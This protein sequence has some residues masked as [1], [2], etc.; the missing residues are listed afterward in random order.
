MSKKV[1][2]RRLPTGV[3][4]LDNLLGGGLPEFSFNLIAGMPGSGKT[5]LAH[6]I[7]FS[8]AN[9]DNRVLF[10]TVLGEPALKMLRYQQQFS[11][12]DI[13][14]INDSIRFVNLSTDLMGGNFDRVLSRISEEVKN[15]TPGLVFVDS[16]RSV[17][18]STKN[19]DTGMSDLQR[20]VQQLGM[21]MT[22]WQTTSFLL[23]EYLAPEAESSPIFTVADGI[24]WLSQNMHH[25]SMVR[26]M[27]VVKMRGQAQAA[28]LHTFR[29]SDE[30]IQVFPRAMVKPSGVVAPSIEVSGGEHRIPTGVPGLDEMLGGGLPAGYSLLLVGPSGSGKT[31]LATEFLA[32]GAARGEPGVIAAFEKSPN[33]LLS[34]KL[35]TLIQAG[36]VG[37]ID[38]RSLDL[39]IDQIL[40][41]LIEMITKMQ[42]KRVVIDS[43]SGFELALAPEFHEDFRGSLYRM[44]AELTGM[45]VTI[46]M[47][48]ELE[49]RYTDLRFSP[50][51]S[52]FLADAIIM[53]RYVEI[54]GQFK[55][56][57]SVVKVRGS[58]HSKD[59]RL[60]DIT[61]EGIVLGET[62]TAHAGIL[63]GR[64]TGD[65]VV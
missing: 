54:A 7:M 56:V 44:I 42:A 8:Q 53:Q 3:P 55:R 36:Q 46:L 5:T 1:T 57:I 29:I 17:V 35:N 26:K 27:Q 41:D 13:D 31:V 16:F 43:L 61:D 64:P 12:F 15:Y 59:I 24:L 22:S 32:E 47:T 25:N 9:S 33:Q 19:Q 18:Q 39:S 40:H 50:F 11:F 60:Y 6:Q 28:G 37:V 52:A 34:R 20:F 23:G 2:I 48:S 45:G 49:D 38:T 62:L 65:R 30:G 58:R 14:K 4:G 51:G 21:Q 63:T 10:F